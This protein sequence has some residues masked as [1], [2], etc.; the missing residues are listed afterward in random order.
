[1]PRF[2]ATRWT[3]LTMAGLGGGLAAAAAISML[4]GRWLSGAVAT[5][6]V[7]AT[8][9]VVL[10][11]FQAAGLRRVL[12]K[13]WWWI[14]ATV[15]GA[16]IGLALGVVIVEEAGA[17]ITGTAPRVAQLSA[18]MRAVSFV[19]I[20]LVGGSILGVAQWM[21]LRAQH[22]AVRRWIVVTGAALAIALCLASLLVDASGV[23]YA[24]ALGR[25]GFLVLSGVMF[26]A[27][28]SLPLRRAA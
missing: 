10:G 7:P 8:I 24:S 12:A 15:A 28:T 25:L 16:G 4:L 2:N 9:G 6:M 23:Q 14:A 21:V 13:P 3:F 26:G 19:V 27:L 5:A 20:G 11:I 1:M 17:L 22:A 18:A